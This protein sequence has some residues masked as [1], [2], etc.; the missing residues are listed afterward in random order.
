MKFNENQIQNWQNFSPEVVKA[1]ENLNSA[2][3]QIIILCQQM[4]RYLPNIDIYKL[5]P[6]KNP[7]MWS[8]YS[9]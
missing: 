7:V 8:K 9:I 5:F 4:F 6:Q 3:R 2:G 1:N